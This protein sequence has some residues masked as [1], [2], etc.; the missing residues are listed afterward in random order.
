M[1]EVGQ[2]DSRWAVARQ[3]GIG[4]RLQPDPLFAGGR[5]VLP[6]VSFA[7]VSQSA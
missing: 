4:G 3:A 5:V 2:R 1:R 6:P 7:Q